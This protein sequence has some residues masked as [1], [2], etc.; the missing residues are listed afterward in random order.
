[1]EITPV[2]KTEV[3]Q[4]N[5]MQRFDP[6]TIRYQ[7]KENKMTKMTRQQKRAV[8]RKVLR[9]SL[10][11]SDRRRLSKMKLS[12]SSSRRS[13]YRTIKSS[14]LNHVDSAVMGDVVSA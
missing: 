8:D 2:S 10:S 12:R 4:I 7:T 5:W 6:F 3:I 11:K 13:M 9:A 1:M 14:I